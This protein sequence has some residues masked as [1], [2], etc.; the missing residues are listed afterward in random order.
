MKSSQ[1]EFSP[2]MMGLLPLFY[3]GWSDSVLSPSEIQLIHQKIQELSF[4]TPEEKAYLIRWTDPKSPP[5]KDIF[6]EW[7][8]AIKDHAEHLTDEEKTSLGEYSYGIINAALR[9]EE[10][11]QKRPMMKKAIKDIEKALG[12]NN[13]VSFQLLLDKLH[14]QK[15]KVTE[16]PSF[17]V[18]QL[19]KALDGEFVDTK[20]RMRK[21]LQ[22]PLFKYHTPRD[23]KAYRDHILTLVKAL[24]KQGLGAYAFPKKYGGGEKMGEHIT[25]FEMLAYHDL[26]LTVKF[27]VQFG[28]FGGAVYE[29]GT[30]YHHRLYIDP[31]G[32]A[33]LLGCFAMTETGHGSNVRGLETTAIY[34]HKDK[35]ISIH[36]PNSESGKEYI[37]NAL[38]SSMAVVFAQL[39]VHGKNHGVHAVM[40]PIRDKNGHLLPGIRVEDNGYKM[41]LNGVDN[42]KLWFDQIKVPKANLL[43][44]YG[45]INEDGEYSSPIANPNKR[46]FIMLGALVAGRICVGLAGVNVSKSA[47]AIAIKYATKRRQ[48]E[49]KAGNKEML[50][51]DY[52]THQRR[53][54]PRVAKTYAYYISLSRLAYDFIR[55]GEEERR[56]IETQ[57]AG[58]KAMATWHNTATVQECREACGGKGFLAENRLPDLK[59]DSDIFTTFEGDNTVLM[60]LVAKGLL[61]E[62]KQ[63]FHDEGFMAVIRYLGKRVSHTFASYNPFYSRMTNAGHL[64]D[65]DFHAHALQYRENKLL[66]SLASRM[67]SYLK[68]RIHPH[69]A[70]LKCQVHMVELAKAYVQRLAYQDFVVFREK[71]DPKVQR[72]LR[73]VCNLYALNIIDENKGWYL[74]SGYM[75][76]VK[77]KA[78][79]RMVT[80]LCQ[81]LRPEVTGLVDAWGIEK[82]LLGAEIIK[83]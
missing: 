8:N 54:I 39:I 22:D 13:L 29:L 44:K 9:K 4:L 77:T 79:R 80:K 12:L 49:G 58:L 47:L 20:I 48:F 71:A 16:Q 33:E 26:S 75:E 50:I 40:V 11:L 37:G 60:Q 43:N 41:G 28:L 62:F 17:P 46:F 63:S 18:D 83:E 23:K 52:P 14:H 34:N 70:F 53:L 82:P 51:M 27:G 81:E 67:Q 15:S 65:D 32:K 68:K 21:L 61:T 74:E 55:S 5:G 38:H 24:A 19:I 31:L 6:K 1:Q 59:A 10:D 56:K 42:G 72:I 64:L 76:G 69:D 57:A 7:V 78:I 66:L 25:V 30:E 35:T 73:K 36:S 3:I 45:D 2:G